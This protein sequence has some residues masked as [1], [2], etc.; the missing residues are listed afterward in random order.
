[1]GYFFQLFDPASVILVIGSLLVLSL[2]ALSQRKDQLALAATWAVNFGT[3]GVL[4]GAVGM[5]ENLTDIATIAPAS[6][7]LYLTFLYGL[8]ILLIFRQ[9]SSSLAD[10]S[11]RGVPH[12]V[13]VLI[14]LVL[15]QVW[16][17]D[18]AIGVSAFID[19]NTLIFWFSLCLVVLLCEK[20]RGSSD[21]VVALYRSLPLL[22]FVLNLLGLIIFL[23]SSTQ[24]LSGALNIALL[25][26]IYSLLAMMVIAT[27]RPK[28]ALDNPLEFGIVTGVYVSLYSG[29]YFFLLWAGILQIQSLS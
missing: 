22:S 13:S 10:S 19:L 29:L 20:M 24:D 27:L 1:M 4:I 5:I 21:L 7:I 23:G 15:I 6:A 9:S 25:P 14:A 8:T 16:A 28:V 3:L 17:M 12:R 18:S 2:G 11:I 26:F